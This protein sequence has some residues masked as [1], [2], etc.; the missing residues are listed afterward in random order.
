M[1]DLEN[2][3]DTPCM[4]GRCA[5]EADVKDGHAVFF[6]AAGATPHPLDLPCCA[7]LVANRTPVLV[8]QAEANDRGIFA[9]YRTL[10]GGTGV[11]DLD[12]L[13]LLP[14]PDATFQLAAPAPPPAGT[15]HVATPEL[16]HAIRILIT[17]GP[18]NP[19]ERRLADRFQA[20]PVGPD[21]FREVLLR[22]DGE[23]LRV[24]SGVPEE[25]SR[26]VA[27]QLRVLVLAAARYPSLAR[28]IPDRPPNARTCAFCEGRDE[29]W[30]AGCFGLGWVP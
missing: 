8:I 19:A 24:E 23:V 10:D 17:T 28:F 5:V 6:L 9:G 7:R 22:P 29:G 16:A 15:L 1:I 27:D 21:L 3:R 12:D 2:W 14:G 4:K 25:R 30:C 20:L 26:S 11:A 13:E 18:R